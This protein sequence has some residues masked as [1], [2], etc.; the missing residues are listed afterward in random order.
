MGDEQH[1]GYIKLDDIAI[2][3]CGDECNCSDRESDGTESEYAVL[4]SSRGTKQYW[5]A[6]GIDLEFH[7]DGYRGAFDAISLVPLKRF[8]S[9]GNNAYL[10]LGN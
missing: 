7:H 3:W 1:L 5:D 2:D 6:K 9:A 4:L 10:E 8:D